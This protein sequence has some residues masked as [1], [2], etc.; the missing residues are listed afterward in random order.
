MKT[1][2]ALEI[3]IA[4]EIGTGICLESDIVSLY[5]I[6]IGE[7]ERYYVSTVNHIVLNT[8]NYYSW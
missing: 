2:L 8:Y 3:G 1:L 5:I 7:C 4:L 6:N